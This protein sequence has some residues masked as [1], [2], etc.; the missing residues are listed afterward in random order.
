MMDDLE[1][2]IGHLFYTT[3]N[4]VHHFKA[5]GEC[6]LELQSRNTQFRSKSV[7]FVQCDFEKL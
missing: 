5:I 7:I 6:E 3:L 1:K 4:F 2:K